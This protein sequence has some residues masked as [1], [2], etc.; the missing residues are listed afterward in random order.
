[1]SEKSLQNSLHNS[2]VLP[3]LQLKERLK[4]IILC[5]KMTKGLE[6]DIIGIYNKPSKAFSSFLESIQLPLSTLKRMF[7]I[8]KTRQTSFYKKH[9]LLIETMPTDVNEVLKTRC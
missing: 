4:I 3:E 1:M 2:E 7:W 8:I 5:R 6:K 9:N